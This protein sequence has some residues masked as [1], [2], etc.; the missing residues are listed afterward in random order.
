MKQKEYTL[1]VGGQTY[2]AIFSDLADQAGGT[3]ML[4]CNETV[5]FATAQMSKEES[6]T[7]WFNLTV[8]YLEKFYSAGKIMGGRFRKREG[9]PS[10]EAVLASRVIDRTIRPLFDQSM[11]HAV[12]ITVTVLALDDTVD[13]ITMATNAASMALHCSDVP[14][15]GPIGAIRLGKRGEAELINVGLKDRDENGFDYDL[16]ICARDNKINMIEA[17]AY[18]TKEE[19]LDS[20]FVR[21]VELATQ[22]ENWQKEIQK[23]EG[24]E[25]RVIEKEETHPLV[26]KLFEDKFRVMLPEYVTSGKSGKE[27]LNKL[28]HLWREAAYELADAQENERDHDKIK[29]DYH[30]HLHHEIDIFVHEAA[31]ERNERCDGRA[32]DTVRDIY[33]GAG[34]ISK[35]L[36]GTGVFYRGETHVLSVLTLGGPEDMQL[37]DGLELEEDKRFMHHYNFPPYSVGETGR[38]GFTGRREVGHGAL[39]EK[40]LEV[41][42]PNKEDFPYTIRIVSES[43]ASNGSTSQAS[44]AG[45]SLALM[46]AGVPIKRHVAGVAMGLMYGSEDNYKLLTDIQ[47][48]EDHHGDMDFKVAGTREG[49]TAIQLDVKVDGVSTKILSEALRGG[50]AARYF[51]LDTMEAEI[52]EP[53][54]ELSEW[55]PRID[56]LSINPDKIGLVIGSGGKTIK[57]IKEKTNAEISIED[58]GT[59][60]LTGEAAGV[61]AAKDIIALMVKEWK[62]GEIA[63]GTVSSVKDFGAFVTLPGNNEGMVHISEIAPFR[64]E[65]VEDVLKVGQEVPVKIIKIE[66]GKIG[67]SIKEANKDFVPTPMPKGK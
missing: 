32:M 44:I 45:S 25:K 55:A 4:K 62:V 17:V 24:K 5:L 1:D 58:D 14:W 47:G 40:A 26:V 51:I 57:E 65:K 35:R 52:A 23:T 59:V 12:Q 37:V 41:M 34:T 67:L 63:K 19:I 56:T 43:M 6:N 28:E 16:L 20:A 53:R 8:D 39:A 42:L 33:A 29:E 10:D 22:F 46:D 66:G 36:H 27:T 64:V 7:P 30:D 13:P 31:L 21:S 48:P 61:A 38:V 3:V 49:V 54:P 9:R 60:Y 11:K 18:E 50:Q 15:A 2:T